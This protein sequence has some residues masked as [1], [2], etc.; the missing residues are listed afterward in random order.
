MFQNIPTQVKLFSQRQLQEYKRIQSDV[1][2]DLDKYVGNL[3]NSFRLMKKMTS[4]WNELK[5]L[6]M[7]N[8]SE[9]VLNE[10]SWQEDLYWPSGEA[11]NGAA[12]GVIHLQDTYNLGSDDLAN[13]RINGLDYGVTNDH[14]CP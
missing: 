1:A 12:V 11:L 6:I 8:N 13:G 2:V 9:P 5:D 14:V 4:D 10:T 7:A 3:I